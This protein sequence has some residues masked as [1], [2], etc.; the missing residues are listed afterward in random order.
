MQRV[1]GCWRRSEAGTGKLHRQST[2]ELRD[3]SR[4][5]NLWVC[6]T[7]S[8]ASFLL[9]ERQGKKNKKKEIRRTA[10]MQR[11][12]EMCALTTPTIQV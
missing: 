6:A 7:T 12:T 5:C 8:N 3:A 2:N 4:S 10:D 9:Q 1:G 11:D